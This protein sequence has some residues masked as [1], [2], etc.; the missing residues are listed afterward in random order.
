[1]DIEGAEIEAL[2]GCEE[3]IKTSQPNFVIASYHSVNNEHTF[4]KVEEFFSSK[5][6][7][8]KTLKFRGS[9]FITFAG[10]DLN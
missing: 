7:P 8:F 3:T 1:M 4:I 9:E 6:Y 10:I 5:N 2:Y